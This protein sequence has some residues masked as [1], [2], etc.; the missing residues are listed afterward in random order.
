[1]ELTDKLVIDWGS[2]DIKGT[3]KGK[4]QRKEGKRDVRGA[5]GGRQSENQIIS[6]R[7]NRV[8]SIPRWQGASGPFLVVW[9]G[10]YIIEKKINK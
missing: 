1:M 3:D 7:I 5:I 10:F 9:M 8:W 6:N 2:P 4:G